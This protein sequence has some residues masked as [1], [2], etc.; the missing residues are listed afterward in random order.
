MSFYLGYPAWPPANSSC[1]VVSDQ[2][3]DQV[4]SVAFSVVGALEGF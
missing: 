1:R 3:S 4:K 2:I